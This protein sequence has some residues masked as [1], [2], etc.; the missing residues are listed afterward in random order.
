MKKQ[1]LKSLLTFGVIAF[2]A[3]SL[4]TSCEKNG[5]GGYSPSKGF[6]N[7]NYNRGNTNTNTC[8]GP[9]PN[10]QGELKFSVSSYIGRN[11]GSSIVKV[12]K[13]TVDFLSNGKKIKVKE[14][15]VVYLNAAG[16]AN[17]I[18]PLSRTGDVG[19][20]FRNTSRNR[21]GIFTIQYVGGFDSP[22]KRTNALLFVNRSHVNRDKI[23][24][25]IS[26][27]CPGWAESSEND[28]AKFKDGGNC[29][30]Y[31]DDLSTLFV[32]SYLGTVFDNTKTSTRA[33]GTMRCH[34]GL[35][36]KDDKAMN[37][38]SLFEDSYGYSVGCSLAVVNNG[39][40]DNVEIDDAWVNDAASVTE[41]DFYVIGIDVTGETI[42]K[43]S[44]AP[45]F[46]KGV[47]D[48]YM[49]NAAFKKLLRKN[50]WMES[51]FKV[52][53]VTATQFNALPK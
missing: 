42:P 10:I 3:T 40:G 20:G 23:S 41:M 11:I 39:L 48:K 5:G 33:R 50:K 36:T 6:I 29:R 15:P 24:L 38:T 37:D 21:I 19:R 46:N 28:F 14:T 7:D 51:N 52:K 22:F 53:I 8:E 26:G 32:Y 35:S 43:W 27:L 18:Q 9:C 45:G 49:D 4:A 2:A 13:E 34:G 25:A 47:F 1:I 30:T 31:S 44:D 16:L 12:R 17:V